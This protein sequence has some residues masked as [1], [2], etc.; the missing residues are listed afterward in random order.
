MI[1][2]KTIVGTDETKHVNKKFRRGNKLANKVIKIS[3]NLNCTVNLS[4]SF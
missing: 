3:N 4:F 2:L 1:Y